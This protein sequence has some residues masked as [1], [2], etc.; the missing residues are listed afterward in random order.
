M[1][2]SVIIPTYNRKPILEKCIKA[3]EKQ[4]LNN[5]FSNYEIVVVDD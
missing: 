2:V 5:N 3:I 1:N 4:N